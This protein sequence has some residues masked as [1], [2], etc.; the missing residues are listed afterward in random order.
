MGMDLRREETMRIGNIATR[1]CGIRD[2]LKGWME[3]G[4]KVG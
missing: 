4:N 1:P 3:L 2:E